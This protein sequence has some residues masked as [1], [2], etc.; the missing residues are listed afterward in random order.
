MKKADSTLYNLMLN[1]VDKYCVSTYSFLFSFEIIDKTHCHF[2]LSFEV[3]QSLRSTDLGEL[4]QA[5]EAY[6]NPQQQSRPQP[7]VGMASGRLAGRQSAGADYELP[8]QFEVTD[9]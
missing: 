8:P 9:V 2:F 3:R 5:E 6:G 1:K 7:Q 4:V